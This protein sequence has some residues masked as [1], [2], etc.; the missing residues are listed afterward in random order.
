M[1]LLLIS[2]EVKGKYY[3]MKAYGGVDV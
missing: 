2:Q 3:I 1:N